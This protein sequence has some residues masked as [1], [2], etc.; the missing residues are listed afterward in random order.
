MTARRHYDEGKVGAA[1]VKHI[2]III[3]D[4]KEVFYY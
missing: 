1:V 2:E 3:G 4:N